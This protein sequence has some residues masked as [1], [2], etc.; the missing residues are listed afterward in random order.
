[1]SALARRAW[2]RLTHLLGG[3]LPGARARR[4]QVPVFER[5]WLAA[6]SE[7]QGA[8]GPLWVVL[9]DS[10][11]QAIGATQR[12]HG[13]VCGVLDAL[14][15]EDPSW[16]VVNLSRT[17]ARVADVLDTQLP[18]LRKLP[19]PAVLSVAIGIND[20]RHRTPDLAGA[21]LTMLDALPAGSVVATVPQGVRPERARALNELIRREAAERGLRVADLWAHT[22]PPWQDKFSADHF[23]PNDLGYADWTAA[24]LEAL[25]LAPVGSPAPAEPPA[26]VVAPPRVSTAER[27]RCV[28]RRLFGPFRRASR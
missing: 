10:G 13:Y 7:A 25:D 20:I 5:E 26:V 8:S 22:G 12:R 23:H 15:A 14:R 1:M 24:F 9:G 18:A 4:T 27:T 21:M 11:S 3:L 16:R 19:K 2:E 17:G 28:G 6:N